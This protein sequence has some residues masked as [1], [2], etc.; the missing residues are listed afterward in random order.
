MGMGGNGEGPKKPSEPGQIPWKSNRSPA[1]IAEENRQA[2]FAEMREE[3]QQM[4]KITDTILR[5]V[6]SE[7]QFTKEAAQAEYGAHIASFN[8]SDSYTYF[9]SILLSPNMYADDWNEESLFL[10]AVA[11]AYQEKRKTGWGTEAINS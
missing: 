4:D 5:R 7:K 8:D 3:L 2:Q 6:E 10:C 9:K 11:L 1:E